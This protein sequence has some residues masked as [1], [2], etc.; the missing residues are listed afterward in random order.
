M[1]SILILLHCGSNTG[2]AIGPLERTFFQ[3]G[4]DLCDQDVRRVHFSYPSMANGRSPTL[5][6]EFNQYAVINSNSAAQKDLSVAEQ[7][8]RNHGIDTIFGFDQAVH[9]PM[10]ARFR[11]AGVRHFISYWGAPMS[12]MNPLPIRLVKSLGVMLRPDGP[13]H[14]IFESNG[15]AELAV[16]GRGIPRRRVSVV[17]QGVDIERYKPNAADTR[18]VFERMRIPE[19]RKVFFYSGHME[20]RKGIAVIMSAANV[21]S[22]RRSRDDWHVLLC[23]NRGEESAQ[24]EKML[25]DDAREHV[26]FG[27]YRDDLPLLQRGCCAGLLATSGWDSFPRS[28][29]EAQSSGLPLIVSNLIGVRELVEDRISGVVFESG[30]AVALASEMERMMDDLEWRDRLGRQ[31]RARIEAKFTLAKQLSQLT[32]V[33]RQISAA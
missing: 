22:K 18:Y 2:Y 6:S 21:L 1:K 14:Y 12:S 33:V 28:G 4:L 19:Q 23:G 26:T 10:Y 9:R 27:G 8:L 7:Y 25:S 5:P 32:E 24:Y 29:L 17:P 20:P 11:R 30:N 3:M 31:A 13:D 15:M 16:K